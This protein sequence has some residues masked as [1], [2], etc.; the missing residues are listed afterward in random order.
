MQLQ[1]TF[2]MV[3]TTRPK[4]IAR[5]IELDIGAVVNT[6]QQELWLPGRSL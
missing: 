6:Y 1:A 5:N 2:V 3:L 4:G